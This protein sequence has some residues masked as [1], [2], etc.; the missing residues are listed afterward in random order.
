MDFYF[1][2]NCW[3]TRLIL[4]NFF[5]LFRWTTSVFMTPPQ[6]YKRFSLFQCF[7]FRFLQSSCSSIIIG[8]SLSEFDSHGITPL[9]PLLFWWVPLS[10][11]EHHNCS[12][13]NK[14]DSFSTQHCWQWI[15]GVLWLRM[16]CIYLHC[17]WCW[18]ESGQLQSGMLFSLLLGQTSPVFFYI[19]SKK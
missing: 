6:L 9:H 12:G 14:Q 11:L 1:N 3:L 8:V 5:C 2:T 13:W 17:K 16:E 15:P 4:I 10:S 19:F 18:A 7:F